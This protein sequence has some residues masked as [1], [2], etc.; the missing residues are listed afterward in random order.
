MG[1]ASGGLGGRAGLSAH[2]RADQDQVGG[3]DVL[4]AAASSGCAAFIQQTADRVTLSGVAALPRRRDAARGRRP[5]AARARGDC[6]AETAAPGPAPPAARNGAPALTRRG[7]NP[8]DAARAGASNSGWRACSPNDLPSRPPRSP[9]GVVRA[10]QGI[11]H[12]RGRA[13]DAPGR[14]GAREGPRRR[15]VRG[16]ARPHLRRLRGA[17]GRAGRRTASPALP[18]G[19]F[20]RTATRRD[21]AAATT[22]AAASW[23]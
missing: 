5:A 9:P 11:A 15:L 10:G 3:T 16:A 18:A 8:A 1:K 23:R 6:D 7:V 20:E 17:R 14:R 22:P 19:R 12:A 13:T 4:H 2:V 21:R